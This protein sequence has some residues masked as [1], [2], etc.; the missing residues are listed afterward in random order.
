MVIRQR[1]IQAEDKQE[2]HDAILDAA[3]RL[4]LRSPERV[5]SVA[6]V[7]DEASLAKGTVYLYFPSKE[8]LLLAVHE[9]GID[10]FFRDVIERVEREPRVE[11][12]AMLQ[13]TRQHLVDPPLFL[14]LASRCFGL[15]AHSIPLETAAAFKQRMSARLERA[16]AGFE[17]HFQ[18]LPPGGGVTLLRRSYAL[19]IGLW[20]MSANAAGGVAPCSMTGP[21][22]SPVFVW[23]YPNELEGA[24]RALWQ[25]MVGVE[26]AS[27][28]AEGSR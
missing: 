17:R 7:A 20:Q 10:G 4:L 22:T 24:L 18:A 1:A 15:M 12:E 26:V 2:R 9:R 13:L 6:E 16:G 19:I 5:A 21:G 8:E 23:S 27:A 14:P 3:V 11:I 28:A 25:G